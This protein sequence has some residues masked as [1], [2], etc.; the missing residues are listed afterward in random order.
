MCSAKSDEILVRRGWQTIEARSDEV[1][2]LLV[3]AD[4]ECLATREIPVEGAK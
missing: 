3:Q 1:R 2:H 4:E